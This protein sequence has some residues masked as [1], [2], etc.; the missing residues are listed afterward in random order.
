MHTG[1]AHGVRNGDAAY[2]VS[3][4]R[5]PPLHGQRRLPPRQAHQPQGDCSPLYLTAV[6]NVCSCSISSWNAQPGF[7]MLWALWRAHQPFDDSSTM[8]LGV[9]WLC[10]CFGIPESTRMVHS[11]VYSAWGARPGSVIALATAAG[12]QS[13]SSLQCDMSVVC[14]GV[15]RLC[16]G[17]GFQCAGGRE[18]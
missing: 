18:F 1:N 3:H 16:D 10:K 4:P 11:Y 5:R 7:C 6:P 2:D 17:L 8:C 15:P 12:P 14:C 9:P 13:T